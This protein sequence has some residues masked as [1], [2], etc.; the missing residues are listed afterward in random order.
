[1]VYWLLVIENMSEEQR[2][3]ELESLQRQKEA[4]KAE[5]YRRKQMEKTFKIQ[6]ELRRLK[7]MQQQQQQNVAGTGDSAEVSGSAIGGGKALTDVSGLYMYCISSPRADEFIWCVD[8]EQ[9]TRKQSVAVVHAEADRLSQFSYA[10]STCTTAAFAT[11]TVQLQHGQC[12]G[13]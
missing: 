4:D 6:R 1:M 11:S 7:A 10:R 2:L 9:A 3:V 12:S 8:H 5:Y 13:Q